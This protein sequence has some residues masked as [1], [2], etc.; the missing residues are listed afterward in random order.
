MQRANVSEN[1]A[2]ESNHSRTVRYDL[3]QK[4]TLAGGRVT[5]NTDVD[6]TTQLHALPLRPFADT[7]KQLKEQALLDLLMTKD[8][9]CDRIHQSAINAVGMDQ[10]FQVLDFSGE[11]F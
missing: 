5:N 4:L 9:G 7:T 1:S 8:H 10:L 2:L 11:R 6:I 3:L